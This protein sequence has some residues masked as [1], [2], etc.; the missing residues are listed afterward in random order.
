MREPIWPTSRDPSLG[1]LKTSR[2]AGRPVLKEDVEA[3]K[4]RA[5]CE[6][7]AKDGAALFDAPDGEANEDPVDAIDSRDAS[8]AS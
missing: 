8:R 3:D 7:G 4:D 5:N 6:G 2:K 1:T